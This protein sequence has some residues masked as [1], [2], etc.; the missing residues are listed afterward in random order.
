MKS[1]ERSP[2]FSGTGSE[3]FPLSGPP[4][5]TIV[6]AVTDVAGA[7]V[8]GCRCSLENFSGFNPAMFVIEDTVLGP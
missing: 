3:L 8:A 6:I 2:V 4:C 7:L 1:A 5:A